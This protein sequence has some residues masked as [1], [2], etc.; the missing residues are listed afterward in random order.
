[1]D[2]LER[3]MKK[4]EEVLNNDQELKER[5]LNIASTLTGRTAIQIEITGKPAYIVNVGEG[6]FTVCQGSAPKPLLTWK[7]SLDL[8]KE[9]ILGKYRLV[10]GLL[11]PRG[12]VSFDS[13]SFTHFN[14]ATIIEMLLLAQELTAKDREIRKLVEG[15]K[16]DKA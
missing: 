4:W 14:G 8:F 15:L 11:D 13:E 12:E 3:F 16:G 10:Y 6:G 7:S 2:N 9:V 5:N 1:M